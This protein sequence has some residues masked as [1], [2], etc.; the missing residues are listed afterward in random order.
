[1]ICL[2]M[3]RFPERYDS[4]CR[5]ISEIVT[6]RGASSVCST[7]SGRRRRATVFPV[8]RLNEVMSGA[9]LEPVQAVVIESAGAVLRPD[10]FGEPDGRRGQRVG[11]GG[12]AAAR[13]EEA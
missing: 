2:P 4:I 3:I 5:P 6:L 7:K 9:K 1:M 10:R 11:V 13:Q 8:R 12:R